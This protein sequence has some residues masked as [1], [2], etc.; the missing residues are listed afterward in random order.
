MR[1]GAASREG[2]GVGA[3]VP[4]IEPAGQD[5]ELPVVVEAVGDEEAP[6]GV[7][8]GDAGADEAW[9]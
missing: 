8:S 5:D 6:A 7:P 9:R 2:L 4:A 3:D 1:G